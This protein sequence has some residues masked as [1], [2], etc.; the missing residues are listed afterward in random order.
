MRDIHL[1]RRPRARGV[2]VVAE[3]LWQRPGHRS[4]IHLDQLITQTQ[5]RRRGEAFLALRLL[6]SGPDS[7]CTQ[8]W[9]C[10]LGAALQIIQQGYYFILFLFYFYSCC[11]P[12]RYLDEKS[13]INT[14]YRYY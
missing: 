4:V 5:E 13:T 8:R 9:V 14:I 6:T 12:L 3:A 11:S 10:R 2:P 1:F 7:I